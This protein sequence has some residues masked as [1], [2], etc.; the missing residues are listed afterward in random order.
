M[1]MYRRNENA[2]KW[3]LMAVE[4]WRRR[5]GGENGVNNLKSESVS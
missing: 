5:R 3:R 1:A 2:V 4:I